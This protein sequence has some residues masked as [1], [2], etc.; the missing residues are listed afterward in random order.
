MGRARRIETLRACGTTHVHD[1]T[2]TWASVEPL[3]HSGMHGCVYLEAPALW[4]DAQLEPMG[5]KVHRHLKAGAVHA[6]LLKRLG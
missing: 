2:N 4:T 5:L 6:H 1:I 3:L